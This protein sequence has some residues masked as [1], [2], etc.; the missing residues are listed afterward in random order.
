MLDAGPHAF[1]SEQKRF[2]FGEANAPQPWLAIHFLL[3][4]RLVSQVVGWPSVWQ[5][6]WLSALN[7]SQQKYL[8]VSL[9]AGV[10]RSPHDDRDGKSKGWSGEKHVS[11]S[12]CGVAI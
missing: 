10:L 7:V 11:S 4:C 2:A 12:F 8:L 3:A 5:A 6:N 1:G 9:L